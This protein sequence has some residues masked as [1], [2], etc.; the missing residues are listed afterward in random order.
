MLIYKAI[1]FADALE[2]E[3]KTICGNPAGI[4]ICRT[5]LPDEQTMAR[6]AMEINQP[7]IAFIKQRKGNEFD[8]KFYFP[9]GRECFLCG[10]GTL[11]A[12]YIINKLYHYEHI[13]LRI[14]ANDFVINCDIDGQKKVR[15]YLSSYPLSAM[16]ADK[17][18]LYLELLG[19]SEEDVIDKLYC[20][21]LNDCVVVLKDCA[22]L[23]FIEPDYTLLSAQIKRDNFRALMI[24]AAS[25]N[26]EIDYEIRVFCPY[27]EHHEDISCGSANCYLLP[28]WKD[29]LHNDSSDDLVILCPFKPTNNAF[30]GI[31]NGNYYLS[32]NA[33]SISGLIHEI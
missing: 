20:P 16:A 5:E 23:R 13:A 18:P 10:H 7:I 12:A 8:I 31:E 19:L 29:S 28:Y 32:E 27:V 30:G 9:D 33:V 4:V 14:Q 1:A 3:G 24:T 2:I 25:K 21:M 6:M 15:A 22:R 26:Q 17:A 11:V